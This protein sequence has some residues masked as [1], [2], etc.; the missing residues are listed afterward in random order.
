MFTG[1]VHS[2][3]GITAQLDGF[4]DTTSYVEQHEGL[5]AGGT[6]LRKTPMANLKG[7]LCRPGKELHITL[8]DTSGFAEAAPGAIQ[9]P[10]NWK[11]YD[12]LAVRLSA[13]R[14]AGQR[15][16][17]IKILGGRNCLNHP[18]QFVSDKPQ[19]ITLPLADLPLTAAG[20]N[21]FEPNYIRFELT[22]KPSDQITVH[23]IQL[24]AANDTIPVPVADSFGQRIRGQWEGK[25]VSKEQLKTNYIQEQ[26]E[27]EGIPSITERDSIGGLKGERFEATGF[28]RVQQVNGIWWFITP[29]GDRFWSL[30]VT[31]IRSKNEASDVTQTKGREYL[32]EYLPPQEGVYAAAW[33]TPDKVSF[34]YLNLLRKYGDVGQWRQTVYQRL[35]KWGINTIGNWSEDTILH[36]SPVPF[37]LSYRTNESP[38]SIGKGFSDVFHPGWIQHVDSVLSATSGYKNNPLLLGYFIDNE[39][40]WGEMKLFDLLPDQAYSRKEWM[41]ILQMKYQTVERLNQTWKSSFSHWDEIGKITGSQ[42]AF[43]PKAQ[44]DLIGF[45]EHFAEQYFK[46]IVQLLKKHDPNHLYLGCRFTRVLKPK[47]ILK[48]AGKYADVVTVNVYSLVPIKADME[49]WYQQTGKPLLIGEHHLPL[50]S[51]RQL[52]PKYRCFSEDER[53]QWYPE[54]V[55]TWAKMPF[56]LGCHWYQ[57]ADQHITGRSTDG[58]NQTVGLID[59]TDTPYRHMTESVRRAAENIYSWHQQADQ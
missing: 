43:Y 21:E 23:Q 7:V 9:L 45:E 10:H 26:K 24:L 20:K 41:K 42:I 54:Y 19:T 48:Q 5:Q 15:L 33:A 17:V 40:G 25:I 50:S 46:T 18:V 44:T 13:P 22:G 36:Q 38:Y 57:F 55:K 32:F 31:G 37:T 14:S 27:L 8:T 11:G 3:T 6:T 52:P 30:G 28:F 35:H 1:C 59:I 34:Y 58:E 12:R 49:Q 2:P 56:S 16:L 29:G 47:H 39:Q 53:R 4:A 51:E